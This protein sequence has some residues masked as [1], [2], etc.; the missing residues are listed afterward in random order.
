MAAGNNSGIG[1]CRRALFRGAALLAVGLAATGCGGDSYI[2]VCD[3]PDE[4]WGARQAIVFA[5]RPDSATVYGPAQ[6]GTADG[7]PWIDLMIRHRNDFPYADLPLEIKGV[8]PDKQFW[9]D[10]VDFPL[11]TPADDGTYRWDGRAYSNH[12]DIT[13]RYRSGIR[14]RTAG[15]YALSIR[16]LAAPD[17]LQGIIAVGVIANGARAT[18]FSVR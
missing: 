12:L 14:Y 17:T 11:A 1:V 3:L 15:E 6:H 7:G 10:T 18:T 4:R 13:R 2:E 8:A 16:Q 9:I 5:F